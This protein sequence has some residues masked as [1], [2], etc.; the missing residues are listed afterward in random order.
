M[1]VIKDMS[2]EHRVIE[3]VILALPN[4]IGILQQGKSPALDKLRGVV[5]FLRE[6]ADKRHHQREEGIVFP[7]LV[8][9]GVPPE[10]CPIGG[11]S[12]DHG[13]GR[14]M[15]TALESAIAK[16]EVEPVA[17]TT[18]L[19]KALGDIVT[20]YKKHLWMEDAMVFPMAERML[21]QDQQ[22]ALTRQFDTL[23]Q[24]LDKAKI[25]EMEAFA[26]SLSF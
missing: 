4:A 19:Q 24:S 21:G 25:Q 23:E 22:E 8:E 16:Y 26:E 3:K 11:L 5:E 7:Q 12:N 13:K 9:L 15:A 6:Y 14:D 20:L 17:A 1:N 2:A 10:G 18:E